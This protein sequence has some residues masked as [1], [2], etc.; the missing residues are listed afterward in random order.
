MSE[1]A[2]EAFDGLA[3]LYALGALG[4]AERERFES[5]LEASLDGVREVKSL[6]PVT[7]H[8][9]LTPAPVDPPPA[10][11]QRV[12]QEA[13][14]PRPDPP[15]APSAEPL[16]TRPAPDSAP[17]AEPLVIRPAPDP[18]PPPEPRRGGRALFWLT[19]FL[20]VAGAGAGGWYAAALHRQIAD[21]QETADAAT[22]Q[23][24]ILRLEAMV[25]ELEAARREEVIAIA[26]DPTVQSLPLAGQPLAP[27]ATGRALW[28]EAGRLAFLATG[29]PAPPAGGAYQIW[30]VMPGRSP[31]PA[32]GGQPPEPLRAAVLTA[33]GDGT[34]AATLEIPEAVTMPATMAVTVE[35]AGAAAGQPSADVFLLGRP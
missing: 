5:H 28:T 12:L 27:R 22:A 26:A 14:P 1:P 9:L 17:P 16:A 4:A 7:H 23:A 20:F 19:A 25:A 34:A 18:A 6:L 8:L 30:F 35:P 24:Q 15:P 33:A 3:A 31:D 32:T 21:L 13:A 11:R 29:L 10:L 2:H